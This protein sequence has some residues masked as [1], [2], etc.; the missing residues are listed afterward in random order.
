MSYTNT[1][2]TIAPDSP[3]QEGEVPVSNR[4]KKPV[5][6]IEYELLTEHPYR[7]NHEGLIFEVF[8]RKKE[9]AREVVERER[10]ILWN[11]L[12][13]KGHPCMRASALTKRYG[14]GAHYNADGAIA[15]YPAG[16]KEYLALVNDGSV[17]KIPAMKQKR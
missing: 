11:D 15:I 13:R 5:H 12:F 3:V 2:I 6:I 14:F 17:K 9:I 4:P 10:E 16:S 8:I 1:F 7:Y